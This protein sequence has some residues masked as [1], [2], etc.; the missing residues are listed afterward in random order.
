MFKSEKSR[1]GSFAM[2]LPVAVIAGTSS[3]LDVAK[4]RTPMGNIVES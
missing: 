2:L 3:S 4:N 1:L